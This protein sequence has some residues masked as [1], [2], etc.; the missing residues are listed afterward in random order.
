L[1]R[2]IKFVGDGGEGG[3]LEDVVGDM[4]DCVDH[5]D[6]SFVEMLSEYRCG[7]FR[8]ARRRIRSYLREESEVRS[9]A[10]CNAC[11]RVRNTLYTLFL[12]TMVNVVRDA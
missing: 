6:S 5:S 10:R 12:S 8:T 2:N 1:V 3:E 4:G 11:S 7:V 9:C